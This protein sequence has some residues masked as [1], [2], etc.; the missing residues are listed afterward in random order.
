MYHIKQISRHYVKLCRK[1]NIK[2]S[3]ITETG[4]FLPACFSYIICIVTQ[5]RI[6][7]QADRVAPPLTK[8]RG[9]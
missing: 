6:Q 8:I 9:W 3:M 7:A 5:G 2:R 4:K 1:K